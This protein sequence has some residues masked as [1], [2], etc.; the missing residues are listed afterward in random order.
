MKLKSF[1][2]AYCVI[3]VAF[4]FYAAFVTGQKP[5]F[6]S[7]S[8]D[9]IKPAFLSLP[10]IDSGGVWPY[11]HLRKGYPPTGTVYISIVSSKQV[12]LYLDT[13]TLSNVYIDGV[14]Y[15]TK[16]VKV[17]SEATMIGYKE[18]FIL[19]VPYQG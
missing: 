10:Y 13:I 15:Q 16:L 4:S 1:F 17:R 8:Q 9:I 18:L 7:D 19:I 11:L 12:G 2:I 6:T 14:P 3:L 5:S